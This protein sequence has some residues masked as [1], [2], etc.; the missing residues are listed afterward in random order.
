MEENKLKNE[1]A[2]V[3]TN[4]SRSLLIFVICLSFGFGVFSPIGVLEAATI[5]YSRS[6]YIRVILED[7]EVAYDVKPQI[8]DG[9]TLVPMRLTFEKM[10]LEIEWDP[11]EQRI[12]G[13]S[14]Y[15]SIVFE[16]GS[17]RVFIDNDVEKILDVPAMIID[18]RTMVPLRFLTESMGYNVV[19]NG[20]SNLILLSK[21]PIV[22]WKTGGYEKVSPYREHEIKFLNGEITDEVRYTGR[23]QQVITEWRIEGYEAIAPFR[24]YERL[25]TNGVSSAETRYTGK[26]KPVENPIEKVSYEWDYPEDLYTWTCSLNIPVEAV[27]L[28]R[29]LNRNYIYS[30]SY[31]VA[32]EADDN[33][34]NSL[35][36]MF[37]NTAENEDLGEWDTLSLAVSFVQSLEYVSDMIGSGYDEYP[38]FP[39]ETLYDKGGD[40]EDT[41]ILLASILRELGYGTVLVATDNHMGVGLKTSGDGNFQYLGMEFYYIETTGVGWEIGE[42]PDEMDGVKI[43][44]IPVN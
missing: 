1:L 11:V 29:E 18:N 39:L 24:E 13:K 5:D 15:F 43:E 44:I 22:E 21:S 26:T 37:L 42:L 40:C 8:V 9:R 10:G 12:T 32:H 30:Y 27:D 41:S 3:I 23:V 25:Y 36:Q 16:I 33:Y 6:Y 35:A 17:R 38:K 20:T 7:E 2:E 14:E 31:Y 28:Y 19:W 4:F 34:M